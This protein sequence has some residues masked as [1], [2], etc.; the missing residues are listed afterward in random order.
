MLH[1]R[2]FASLYLFFCVC[3]APAECLPPQM[4][5][6]HFRKNRPKK[7][8]KPPGCRLRNLSKNRP[9]P[10]F[11]RSTGASLVIITVCTVLLDSLLQITDF[12]WAQG[13][14]YLLFKSPDTSENSGL[15]CAEVSDSE[16]DRHNCETLRPNEDLHEVPRGKAVFH[17]I[18][19][20]CVFFT[21]MSTSLK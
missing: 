9:V 1:Q 4:T 12:L 2:L 19:A 10:I 5:C 18:A 14:L 8:Q 17:H 20:R 3:C 7:R 21:Q 16:A 13:L 6:S 11:G 15:F